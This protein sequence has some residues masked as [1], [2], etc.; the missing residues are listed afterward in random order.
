MPRRPPCTEHQSRG[1]NRPSMCGLWVLSA[2]IVCL[3]CCFSVIA[4]A[5]SGINHRRGG[6]APLGAGPADRQLRA[7]PR[8]LHRHGRRQRA[9]VP[10]APLP[11]AAGVD[12]LQP[13]SNFCYFI[14]WDGNWP[15]A[16]RDARLNHA[17]H[18]RSCR[19]AHACYCAHLLALRR[20]SGHLAGFV[21]LETLECAKIF[22][23]WRQWTWTLWS[24]QRR[25]RPWDS[26]Q[27]GGTPG[28]YGLRIAGGPYFG[29]AFNPEVHLLFNCG[30]ALP[31]PSF[32]LVVAA[33]DCAP[34]KGMQ[35][36]MWHGWR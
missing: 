10:V 20:W 1:M 5:C 29:K 24:S 4:A 32:V 6:P 34:C 31:T 27:T 36:I 28:V 18:V 2:R 35:S 25:T 30:A 9:A 33:N 11:A 19:G 16:A 12:T 23:R 22:C 13:P 7:G 14:V 3:C 26:Q 21:L 15:W 17:A 8:R